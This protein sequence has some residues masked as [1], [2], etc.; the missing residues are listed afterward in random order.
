MI[1]LIDGILNN[2]QA[3]IMDLN[4]MQAQKVLDASSYAN[5]QTDYSEFALHGEAKEGQT[6]DQVRELLL[7]QLESLKRG[8]FD[9]WLIEAVVNNKKQEQ[10]RFWNE[11]NGMRASAMTD[12]FILKKNWKD[13]V[14]LYDR[15]GR[16]TKQQ[17]IDFAKKN[18]GTNYVCVYKR[19]GENK[20]AHKVTKPKITAIDIKRDGKSAWRTEWEKLPSAAMTPEFVDFKSAIDQRMLDHG[21]PLARV[22]NPSNDL[23]SLRY[24]LD[25]G[26][27]NDRELGMAVAYL[28]YLGTTKY[29]PIGAEEGTFQAGTFHRRVRRGGPQLCNAERTREVPGQRR[30]TA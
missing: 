5:V 12:A 10:I 15:M 24:I 7:S 8:E 20:D 17:V 25:M 14:D 11:N 19:T 27:N 16:I 26:T 29:Q 30:G 2:G 21:V 3:G 13:V 9:D 18:L 1:Q 4:L 28:P 22:K 23:F 6:L